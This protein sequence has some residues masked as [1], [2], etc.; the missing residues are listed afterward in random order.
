MDHLSGLSESL[1]S[2]RRLFER[3]IAVSKLVLLDVDD[4]DFSIRKNVTPCFRGHVG[5]NDQGILR[6][7][8]SKRGDEVRGFG[9]MSTLGPGENGESVAPG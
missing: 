6:R 3:H 9:V 8:L 4:E 5:D 7:S 2:D 1:L